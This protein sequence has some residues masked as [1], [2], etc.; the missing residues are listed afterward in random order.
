MMIRT[1]AVAL[2]MGLAAPAF[3]QLDMPE[4]RTWQVEG[5]KVANP[6]AMVAIE[7]ANETLS[8][9]HASLLSALESMDEAPE[10]S[11]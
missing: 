7:R 6:E 10:S 11:R 1:A 4:S 3:A 9:T 8:Q 2:L 5:E